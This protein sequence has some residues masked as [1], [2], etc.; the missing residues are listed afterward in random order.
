MCYGISKFTLNNITIHYIGVIFTGVC[1]NLYI[2]IYINWYKQRFKKA[3]SSFNLTYH[4]K[5]SAVCVYGVNK[6]KCTKWT[7][8]SI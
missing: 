4:L 2:Y 1:I 3:L 8:S 5:L 6:K 7:K